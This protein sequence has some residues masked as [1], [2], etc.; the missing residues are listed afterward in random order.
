MVL[1]GML[2]LSGFVAGTA[3]AKTQ[4]LDLTW[5]ERESGQERQL[6]AGEAFDMGMGGNPLFE[7]PEPLTV[8]TNPGTVTCSQ[9]ASEGEWEGKVETHNEATDKIEVLNP[10][11]G[12]NDDP[13]FEC[14]NTT[15]LGEHARILLDADTSILNLSGSKRKAQVKE[16]FTQDPIVRAIAYSGG[17]ACVYS[18]KVFRETLLLRKVT[19]P[20][21]EYLDELVLHFK[22][23][24]V[25]ISRFYSSHGCP[26]KVSVTVPFAFVHRQFE[27]IGE[28][29]A[30]ADIFGHL[31]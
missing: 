1:A 25:K 27:K 13:T 9:Y 21:L 20:G 23:Q 18:T 26:K 3:T 16:Q 29:F 30:A 22:K 24:K 19:D 4:N 31:D 12:L 2:V 15:G 14:P 7:G 8:E 28:D 5:F 11:G 6:E 10:T 17:D